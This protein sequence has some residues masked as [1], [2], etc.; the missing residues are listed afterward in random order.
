MINIQGVEFNKNTQIKVDVLIV[1]QLKDKY[2]K[3]YEKYFEKYIKLYNDGTVEPTQHNQTEPSFDE[4]MRMRIEN[5][6]SGVKQ[7]DI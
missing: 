6:Y 3:E 4:Y 1:K 5:M 2:T 7:M